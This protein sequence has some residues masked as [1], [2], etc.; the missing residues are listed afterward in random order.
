MQR[1]AQIVAAASEV[2]AS[3]P[4]D[5]VSTAQL[6][7]V[8]GVSRPL[9]NHYF[10][11][12]R[13]LYVAVVDRLFNEPRFDAPTFPPGTPVERRI[14]IGVQ[15][16]VG[17]V[18]QSRETWLTASRFL[19]SHRDED[20]TPIVDA[21]VDTMSDE[22]CRIVG[23]FDVRDDPAVRS[24][25]RAYSAFATALA[26][27][28]LIDADLSREQLETLLRTTLVTLVSRAIPDAIGLERAS[29]TSRTEA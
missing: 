11:S 25:L 22:I 12:K 19:G 18:S 27:R 10:A 14:A 3:H 8:C 15:G 24:A 5:E 28:W 1:R 7:A 2:F 21:Y 20:L 16:W 29:R 26:R 13:D 4:Y 6:A 23:L 9:L 17:M